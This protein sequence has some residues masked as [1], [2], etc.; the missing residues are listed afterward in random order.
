MGDQAP[1]PA[2]ELTAAHTDPCGAGKLGLCVVAFVHGGDAAARDAH[3]AVLD[4]VRLAPANKVRARFPVS[5]GRGRRRRNPAA[6]AGP[7]HA[8]YVGGRGVPSRR[9][10]RL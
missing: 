1:A 2:V 4:A 7:P 8:L 9:C 10:R 5:R 6:G 3:L